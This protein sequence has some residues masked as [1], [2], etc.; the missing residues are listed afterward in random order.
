MKQ[1][2][3]ALITGAGSGIGRAI[4]LALA[5]EGYALALVGRRA[6]ALEETRRLCGVHAL[7]I[8][9][10]VT[11]PGAVR[12]CV[13]EVASALGGLHVLVNNAG[14]AVNA[15]IAGHD[16][17]NLRAMFDINSLAPAIATSAAWPVFERQRRGCIINISSMA[18]LD[19]FPGFFGYAASKAAVNMLTRIAADEG[20]A[21]G[22]RAFALCPGA[23]ETPML[24]GLFSREQV[25]ADVALAP[26]AVARVVCA[27]LRGV[28]DAE[29][30]QAVL[31]R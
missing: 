13:S 14:F 10:D 17:Q 4:A 5:A 30:G 3:A 27:C 12:R 1:P 31:V 2:D 29:N 28:H 6:D 19:P 21:I 22:V 26:E 8:A 15:P 25:P 23:I 18:A 24:R 20:R 11:A 9:A 7:C 16:E